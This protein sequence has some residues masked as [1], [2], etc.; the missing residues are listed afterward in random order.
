VL[1]ADIK[2]IPDCAEEGIE[3]EEVV[4]QELLGEVGLLTC[5]GVDVPNP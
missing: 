2:Y 5:C 1:F 3:K 4:P